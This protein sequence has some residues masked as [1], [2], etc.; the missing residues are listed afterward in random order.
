MEH[1]MD[2]SGRLGD[3][4]ETRTHEQIETM[5]MPDFEMVMEERDGYRFEDRGKRT[6]YT[7]YLHSL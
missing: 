6:G 2:S 7:H 1:I 5:D 3:F 4:M